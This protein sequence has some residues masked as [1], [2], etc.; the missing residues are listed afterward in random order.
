VQREERAVTELLEHGGVVALAER[1]QAALAT[2]LHA[3]PLTDL[4]TCARA[5]PAFRWS[6]SSLA[7][8]AAPVTRTLALRALA[9]GPESEVDAALGRATRALTD[10]SRGAEASAAATLLAERAAARDAARSPTS[11]RSS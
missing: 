10:A 6:R 4:A 9:L 1:W 2:F 11:G 5:V 7:L 3:T 8:A